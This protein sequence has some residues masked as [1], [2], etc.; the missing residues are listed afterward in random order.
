VNKNSNKL[1]ELQAEVE[2]LSSVVLAYK[3]KAQK[4]KKKLAQEIQGSESME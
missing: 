4:L 1:K 3:K 2:N